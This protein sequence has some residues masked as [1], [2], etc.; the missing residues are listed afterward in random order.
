ME[1]LREALIKKAND[2]RD[3]WHSKCGVVV[4]Y[5]GEAVGWMNELRDPQEWKPGC[6]AVDE[7][8]NIFRAIGGDEDS[9][10]EWGQ[11]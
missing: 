8:G 9:A 10:K 11:V 6:F 5:K 1:I 4:I 7:Q 3:H 2:Y